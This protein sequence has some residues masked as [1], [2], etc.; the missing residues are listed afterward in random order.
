MHKCESRFIECEQVVREPKGLLRDNFS[1]VSQHPLRMARDILAEVM[2]FRRT[3]I[4]NT[5]CAST[6]C[7]H[8][9]L[10]H[11]NKVASAIALG[12]PIIFVLPAFPGKSPNLAKVLGPLPDMA[13]RLA[14]EVL[15]RLCDRIRGLYSPGARV[16]LCA[17]GRV[18]SDVVGMRE[19]DVTTY[20]LELAKIIEESGL[21]SL[22]RFNLDEVSENLSF[23]RMRSQLM[24]QFGTEL[25]VLKCAVK[26]G[27]KGG[28]CSVDDL[29]THHLYCGITKFL[30]EDSLFPGQTKS[31]SALQKESRNK[32]YEVIRRSK[33]W[34][35]LV[36][37]RFPGAVRLSIHPQSCGASKIGIRLIEPDNWL[38]PWHAVAVDSGGR[39]VLFKRSEAEKMGAQLIHRAGIPSHYKLT[40]LA[41]ISAEQ[42]VQHD[43]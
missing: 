42:E 6:S 11:L 32:A 26:R 41:E 43:A 8:C 14:L 27:A 10:P 4:T 28:N 40:K 13:E 25:E 17:D 18:F 24:E 5:T 30:F 12:L 36:E 9:A 39:F 38:T 33:A 23:E 19:E 15:Q 37:F 20:Q 3:T 16:I 22:S 7:E 31:R 29:E 2:Q 1:P 34:G 35:D 21:N